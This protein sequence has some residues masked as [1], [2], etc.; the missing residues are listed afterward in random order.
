[1]DCCAEESQIPGIEDKGKE[2]IHV[3]FSL[4]CNQSLLSSTQDSVESLATPQEADLDDEQIRA[5][6]AVFT[7]V[8]AGARSVNN[9]PTNTART[10]LHTT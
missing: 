6:L 4:P 2:L 1:M 9:A 5:L 8:L 10:E 3:P 7:T